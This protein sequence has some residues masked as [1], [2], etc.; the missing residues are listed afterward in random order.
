MAEGH[1]PHLARIASAGCCHPIATSTPAE[2]TAAWATL[3]TGARAPLHGVFDSVS[4]DPQTGAVR[5]A[6][7]GEEDSTLASVSLFRAF[8]AHDL[9][10]LS[11]G[12]PLEFLP[13]R[14]EGCA[15]GRNTWPD[16]PDGP[17]AGAF[18]DTEATEAAGETRDPCEIVHVPLRFDGEV[19]SA[20]L[21]GPAGSSVPLRF[22]RGGGTGIA[23][24][25]G[26][27]VVS[28]AEGEW[29][30][31]VS[32]KFP[33]ARWRHRD[34]LVR[35]F[36]RA[37]GARVAV[38]AIRPCADPARP[39]FPLSRPSS[40]SGELAAR[41]GPWGFPGL[42]DDPMGIDEGRF[43]EEAIVEQSRCGIEETDRVLRREIA[44]GRF[45][46]LV[47]NADAMD[48][49][50]HF[51]QAEDGEGSKSPR[52]R[53]SPLLEIYRRFDRIVG[54]T[55]DEL[56]ERDAL[57][58]VSLHGLVPV[59]SVVHLND[60]LE[61]EGFLLRAEASP[62]GAALSYRPDSTRAYA[63]GTSSIYL[64]R[65]G[66]EAGG[67]V[68]GGAE[69][70]A[71]AREIASR[72]A[73]LRDPATGARVLRRILPREEAFPGADPRIAPDLL[74]LFEPGYR[75][76]WETA[77]G[78]FGGGVVAPYRGA[79]KADHLSVDP[80]AVPGLLFSTL[81]LAPV[82][83]PALEDLAPTLLSCFGV[84]PLSSMAGKAMSFRGRVR[85]SAVST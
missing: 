70:E 84:L 74:L 6:L 41:F 78:R 36:A 34:A 16:E 53:A 67:I 12:V 9:Q 57:F 52:E 13:R 58:V 31:W 7:G 45:D 68:P 55:L 19:A 26:R 66:R 29:S 59:R 2:G 72:L 39:A 62:Q 14:I 69:A 38:Y 23:I 80:A 24:V 48:R 22:L 8:A 30:P 50:A 79:W 25:V 47:A 54:G 82:D 35:F 73:E 18:F 10:T 32:V 40:Y 20:Q 49:A 4:R 61:E 46:F 71:T 64:N 3:L 65:K 42:H 15:L 33:L 44:Q 21:P 27:E 43:T 81:P 5:P 76:S 1:L 77:R 85:P 28:L 75:A 83:A 51:L 37:I 63:L 56:D 60:W 11:L 17:P